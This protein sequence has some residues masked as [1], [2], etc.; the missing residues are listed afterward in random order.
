M[1]TKEFRLD[2]EALISQATNGKGYLHYGYWPSAAA[3]EMTLARIGLAQQHY[4]DLLLASLPAGTQRILDVGSG[5]GSNALAFLRQGLEVDCVCP[6]ARLNLLAREKLPASCQ[7]HETTF[8]SFSSPQH[9]DAL[10]F[11]ESFHY[12]KTSEALNQIDRYARRGAVIFDYFPRGTAPADIRTT[13][14]AFLALV[15]RHLAGRFEIIGD[16]DLTDNIVPTFEVL[17]HIKMRLIRPFVAK[18]IEGFRQSRPIAAFLLSPLLRRLGRKS[19][20]IRDR[21]QSFK[22]EYEYRLIRLARVA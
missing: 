21:G 2:V 3:D 1:N 11:A 15:D 16:E 12:L 10:V 6:S 20:V 9:Y 13:H 14:A 22:N 8:E 17:D 5:T 19:S 4:F 7:I 18:S